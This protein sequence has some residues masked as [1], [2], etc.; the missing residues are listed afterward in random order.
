MHGEFQNL[1]FVSKGFGKR[2]I[3][4]SIVP[5]YDDKLDAFPLTLQKKRN[6][7]PDPP[8]AD[9]PARNQDT[10]FFQIDSEV[11]SQFGFVGCLIELPLYW[12]AERNNFFPRNP[13][14]RK[15]ADQ[16][17]GRDDIV[18]AVSFFSKGNTGIIRCDKIGRRYRFSIPFEICKDFRRNCLLYTSFESHEPVWKTALKFTVNA[19]VCYLLAYSL[20]KPLVFW[21][22]SALALPQNVVEQLSDVYKRQALE[23]LGKVFE[24]PVHRGETKAPFVGGIWILEVP[25]RH[26][27]GQM[28][29]T[30]CGN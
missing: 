25:G 29:V 12:D 3:Q 6:D 20:A 21:S 27:F 4:F 30:R 13:L 9:A 24:P 7:P 14:C 2:L 19:A 26:K 5:A 17:H 16:F 10:D 18:V 8:R 28:A 22:L 11:F 15:L 1:T 23:P